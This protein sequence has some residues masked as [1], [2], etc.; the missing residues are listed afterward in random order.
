MEKDLIV[1]GDVSETAIL[2]LKSRIIESEKEYPIISDPVGK[3]LLGGLEPFLS[4][5]IKN[6]ILGKKGLS[7]ALTSYIALRADKYDSYVRE[8]LKHHP[9]GIIVSLGCGFDTRY[10][11]AVNDPRRYFE[12]DLPEV[13]DLKRK[14]LGGKFPYTMISGSVLDFEWMDRISSIQ[15]EEI[16]FIAEGLLMYLEPEKVRE[17]I[18]KISDEFSNSQMVAEVVDE[19]YTRGF[20]KKITESKMKRRAGTSAGSSFNFGI[21]KADDFKEFGNGIEVIEEW[22]FMEDKRVK[23]I[24]LR[25]FRHFKTFTRS[26]WTVRLSIG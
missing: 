8:F 20:W 4:Q 3:K 10:W 5:D 13:I 6:R 18:G 17:L 19:K 22:S 11:R 23:P 7:R 26:Q 25:F 15:N 21:R 16:L 2:T 9:N 24:I 1:I 14:A 12:L